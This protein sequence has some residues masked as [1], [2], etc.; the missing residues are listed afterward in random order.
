M[1]RAWPV[2]LLVLFVSLALVALRNYYLRD[3][4]EQEPNQQTITT[5]GSDYLFCFW[6]VENLF[7]DRDDG[8]TG[9]GDREY[10]SWFA[11]DPEALK[12]KLDKLTEALIALNDNKGPDV[13]AVCE[14]EGTRAAEM[15]KDALNARLTDTSLHY[16]NVLVKDL[17]A[18]RHITPA[19][20]TRLPV[21]KDR[22]R[23]IGSRL[24]I[25][26]GRVVVDGHELIVIASHWTS[27]LKKEN[28]SR[29]AAYADKIYGAAN[30]TFIANRAADLLVCGDF[31]DSP[32]SPA[33][34]E[35]LHA[36][37]DRAAVLGSEKLL[38]YNLLA[39]KD[40]K[41][42]FGT[43]YYRGW[44]TYDQILVTPGMLDNRGWSC[45]PETVKVINTLTRPGD[46]VGRPWRFGS[47][48]E[49]GVRGYSDHFPVTVRLKVHRK[50]ETSGAGG[51]Q[52][53]E[54]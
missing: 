2:T 54:P 15:L 47:E 43:H 20:I 32:D 14:I 50:A 37:G 8:R 19:I 52:S 31:N 6:N 7:D 53:K 33:V 36:T 16:R 48:R 49:K 23:L 3:E 1:R 41:A 39:N 28:E 4:G 13:L 35:H 9:P 21:V 29:R 17:N 44:L 27:Q 12:R 26:E 51:V 42:G 46:K 11:R 34:T 22:T 30:A 24:R 25:L 10:D 38:F 45:E 5:G 18:G 40:P